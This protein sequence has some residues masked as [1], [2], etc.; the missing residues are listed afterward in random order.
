MAKENNISESPTPDKAG[1][2]AWKYIFAPVYKPIQRPYKSGMADI[3]LANRM[4]KGGL[5]R[6]VLIG[7]PED[8]GVRRNG[9]RVGAARGPAR[10]RH[11]LLQGGV[12]DN[13]EEAEGLLALKVSDAGDVSGPTLEEAQRALSAKVAQVLEEGGIPFV[14][15]GGNDQSYANAR[16]LLAR[17]G[18]R[19]LGVVNVDAHLDVRPP[20]GEHKI[21]SGAPFRLLLEDERFEGENL[22]EFAAQGSRVSR[23]HAEFVRERRGRILWLSELR[24]E[25]AADG[26]FQNCLGDLAWRCPAI[27][28]SFDLD[29]MAGSEAPGVS[30]PGIVGLKAEEALAIAY[31]AGAHPQVALF[32]LSEYNPAVEDE[33]TGRLAAGLFYSF[34]LGVADRERRGG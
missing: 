20:A 25:G 13:P 1:L 29:V 22:I 30:A 34:C 24:R 16:A 31:H 15:G 11:W 32:D 4:T 21:H 9:G 18:T 12:A 14:V 7:Y 23:E 19:P 3:R 28:V 8:E 2:A 17:A 6:V 27:F 5:G 33:R 10:F 26:V